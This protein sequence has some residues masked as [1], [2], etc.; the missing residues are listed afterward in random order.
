MKPY[1]L[2]LTARDTGAA[3]HIGEIARQ[4]KHHPLF[5]IELY[6]AP[7]ADHVLKSMGLEVVAVNPPVVAESR[8]TKH[9]ALL[10]AADDILR[11]TQPDAV[12]TGLSGYGAGIDEAVIARATD[13]PCYTFQDYWGDVNHLFDK[14]ADCYFTLDDTAAELTRQR[15][16]ADT[17]TTGSPKHASYAQYDMDMQRNRMRLSL[18]LPAE[19]NVIALFGQPIKPQEDFLDVVTQFANAV[20]RTQQPTKVLYRPHPSDTTDVTN[21]VLAILEGKNIAP[22]NAAKVDLTPLLCGC[23]FVCSAFSSCNLDN[24]YLNYFSSN[25]LGLSVYLF[26]NSSMEQTYLLQLGLSELPPVDMGFAVMCRSEATLLDT[27]SLPKLER[28]QYWLRIKD[29]LPTPQQ[30]VNKILDKIAR[31]LS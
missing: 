26:L 25:P 5:D 10:H 3:L 31:D 6:A 14:I 11:K 1:R 19:C 9:Q 7:P 4:A 30:A 2:L 21:K 13:I 29:K 16:A 27:L 22:L 15:F 12:L 8:G 28:D 24:I 18:E 23:D 20:D 17:C